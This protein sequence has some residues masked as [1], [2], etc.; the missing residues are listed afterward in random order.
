LTGRHHIRAGVYSWIFDQKQKS[1]LLERETT[2]AECL[3]KDGYATA[4]IGKWHLGHSVNKRKKPTPADHGF[5]HWF[6]TANN[7]HPSHKNPSNFVRNGKPMG[8]LKGYSA[9]NVADEALDWLEHHRDKDAPFFL[10]I[11]FHEPH[12]PLAAPQDLIS[13]YPHPKKRH[14]GALYSGT[15]HNTDLAIK[16]MIAKIHEIDLPENTI[17]IYSSDNGSFRKDRTGGLRDK[18]GSNWDGGIR[19]PGIFV[20]PG[21]IA[22]SVQDAPAGLVDVLPT[23]CGLLDLNKPNLHLDGSDLS[24]LL[25]KNP[26]GFERHQPLFWHLQKSRPIVAMRDGSYSLVA[27]PAYELST[28]NMFEESWIPAIKKGTYTNYQLFDLSQDPGQKNNIAT[29]HPELL[30]KLKEK[31]L[32]INT[33]VMADGSDWHLQQ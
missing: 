12:T 8:E 23:L 31:L 15:I 19:V 32:S 14:S 13:Q 29:K 1:H 2:I 9:Q 28:K 26:Q 33:S 16:R 7:A 6:S 4:H 24:P 22:P 17:I 30:I 10:N 5:D 11:W 25:L 21:Q 27:D 20:W 3:K 18:K